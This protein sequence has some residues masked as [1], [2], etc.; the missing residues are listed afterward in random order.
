M[1]KLN[2]GV[3]ESR[4][5]DDQDIAAKPIFDL[6]SQTHCK[7]SKA[8]IYGMFVSANSFRAS[9]KFLLSQPSIRCLCER[10]WNQDECHLCE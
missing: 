6:L 2:L 8:Y 3:L 5:E 4:W 1:R 9:A 7:T 10:S